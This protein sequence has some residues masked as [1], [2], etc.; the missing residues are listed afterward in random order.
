M[1]A[2]GPA[3]SVTLKNGVVVP[4]EALRLGWSLE[5]RGVQF[6]VDGD[7]LVLVPPDLVRPEEV[8]QLRH[9]CR[10]LIELVIYCDEVRA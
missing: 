10:A 3:E 5:E 9:Y 6:S 7:E 2:S 1:T 8:P 4:L